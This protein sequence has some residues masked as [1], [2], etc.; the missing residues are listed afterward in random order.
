MFPYTGKTLG[1]L[2][3]FGSAFDDRSC[4]PLD[5]QTAN[6]CIASDPNILYRTAYSPNTESF[7]EIWTTK[8]YLGG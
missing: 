8:V 5:I 2:R 1:S 4:I 7:R 6:P 3:S